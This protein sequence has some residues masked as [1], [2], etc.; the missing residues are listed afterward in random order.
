MAPYT[1]K[2]THTHRHLQ[3]HTH[4]H[5]HTHQ[6]H[7]ELLTLP[8]SMTNSYPKRKPFCWEEVTIPTE[9]TG[10]HTG[11]YSRTLCPIY[12]PI[13]TF[14]TLNVLFEISL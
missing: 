10:E 8:V 2:H 13:E 5:K 7:T 6:T 4:T 11:E 14:R 12:S 3:T 9:N 1:N